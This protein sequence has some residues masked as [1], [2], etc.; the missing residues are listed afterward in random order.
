MN[1]NL[2][3]H[4]FKTRN[5]QIAQVLLGN[6]R[7][8]VIVHACKSGRFML[9]LLPFQISTRK[10]RLAPGALKPEGTGPRW[11]G[12]HPPD[13]LPSHGSLSSLTPYNHIFVKAI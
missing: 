2:L 10:A 13:I 7:R 1:E 5:Y 9:V 11:S 4:G 12:R 8:Q 6:V 3:S